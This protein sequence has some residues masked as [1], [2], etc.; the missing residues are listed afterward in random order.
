[1]HA[2]AA[3]YPLKVFE[4]GQKSNVFGLKMFAEPDALLVYYKSNL[5]LEAPLNATFVFRAYSQRFK[6]SAGPY[7]GAG[8]VGRFYA[9]NRLDYG[10]GGS[11]GY[12]SGKDAWLIAGFTMGLA[13]AL[14]ENDGSNH[15][16]FKLTIGGDF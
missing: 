16:T 15:F 11:V 6:I 1:M 5:W 2:G 13:E 8:L 3:F 14:K 10:Y 9:K 4:A 7:A 12:E